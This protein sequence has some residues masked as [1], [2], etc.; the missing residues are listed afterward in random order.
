[1]VQTTTAATAAMVTVMYLAQND[2]LMAPQFLEQEEAPVR[3]LQSLVLDA[4][5]QMTALIHQE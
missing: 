1:M 4:E 2:L 5:E 3:D